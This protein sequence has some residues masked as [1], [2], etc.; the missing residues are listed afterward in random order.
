MRQ[1][2]L[3][4][5]YPKSKSIR[6]VGSNLRTIDHRIVA[7][8]RDKRFYDG[9]RNYGYGGFKYDGRWKKIASKSCEEYNLDENSKF[10]QLNCEKGFL[11]N[12]LKNLKS[13]MEI[14]GL[15]TS[16]Y[17]IDNSMENVKQ[18]IQKCDNY[19]ELKYSD[20]YFDFVIALGVVYTHN[21]TDAIKCLKEIQRVSKGKSFVT[22]ASYKTLEDYWLFKKWSVLG[23]TI[24]LEDE[25]IKLL[26]HSNYNSDYFFTNAQTLNLKAKDLEKN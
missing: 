2:N 26:Q 9:D 22:L 15:E 19:L 24:L 10:L 25:W 23:T 7:T 1:F 20:R 3:L 21:L 13:N 4:S 14:Y 17:A 18:N 5:D 12:D 8:Y 11:L 6:Y 16:K